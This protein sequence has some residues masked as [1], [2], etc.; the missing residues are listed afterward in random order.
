[1]E[2]TRVVEEGVF[3]YKSS[4]AVT[5]NIYHTV[6][7]GA[8]TTAG[9]DTT[10]LGLTAKGG[11]DGGDAASSTMVSMVDREVVRRL[12]VSNIRYWYSTLTIGRL[13]HLWIRNN[14]G[15]GFTSLTHMQ[16]VEVVVRVQRLSLEILQ[17][18]ETVEQVKIIVYPDHLLDMPVVAVV[19]LTIRHLEL[20]A[21]EVVQGV[22]N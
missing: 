5:A 12:L 8:A 2:L 16:V 14:G 11:G 19:E 7:G 17:Q 9:S 6:A 18:V 22:D 15:S 13:W 1:M 20:Q 10:A 4:H 3:S 21:M